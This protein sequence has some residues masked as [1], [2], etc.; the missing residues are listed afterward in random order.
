MIDDK[1]LHKSKEN[2]EAILIVRNPENIDE[3][4][5][6]LRYCKLLQKFHTKFVYNPSPFK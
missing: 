4:R 1:G 6:F 5:N 2:T 3:L